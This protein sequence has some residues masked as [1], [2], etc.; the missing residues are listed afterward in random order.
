MWAMKPRPIEYAH[1]PQ[2][3]SPNPGER[4]ILAVFVVLFAAALG[5]LWLPFIVLFI[6]G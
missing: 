5:L 4:L 6:K 3:E 2:Q 1:P